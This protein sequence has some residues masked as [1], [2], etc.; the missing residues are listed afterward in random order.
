MG[1]GLGFSSIMVPSSWFTGTWLLLTISSFED[2]HQQQ[3]QLQELK[4]K[5]NK[6]RRMKNFFV[7][8]FIFL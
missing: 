5:T 8:R 3:P 4:G 2:S 6:T 1:F 7:F